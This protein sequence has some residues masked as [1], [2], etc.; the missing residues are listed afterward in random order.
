[1][2]VCEELISEKVFHKVPIGGAG[3]LAHI[4]GTSVLAGAAAGGTAALTAANPAAGAALGAA[5][6]GTLAVGGGLYV[7]ALVKCKKYL[8]K[9]K[10]LM[11]KLQACKD[12]KCKEPI[13]KQ[14]DKIKLRMKVA[15]V[16]RNKAINKD[17][18]W[19]K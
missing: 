4:G 19:K 12:D 15:C 18:N 1:M 5:A 10:L 17:N 11:A 9:K 3:G 8:E 2:I 6:A 16:G 7:T 14:L 13:Q